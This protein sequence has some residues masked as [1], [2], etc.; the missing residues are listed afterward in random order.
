MSSVDASLWSFVSQI[1]PTQ[2]QKEAASRSHNFLRSILRQGP[3]ANRISQDYLSGSYARDTAVRPI[4]DVDVV[5][6]LVPERWQSP[7]NI[8][9]L[10]S[11]H[12]ILE[13]F[14]AAIRPKYPVSAVFGQRRSVR[15]EL[16]HLDID[17]VPA[18]PVTGYPDFVWIPDR[19]A[20]S[21][22]KSSPKRH[23]EVA[24]R[25][26]AKQ[27]ARLKPLIKLM[28]YWNRGLPDAARFKSFAV[29]TLLIRLFDAV[30]LP[31]L[32]E[33]LLIAFDFLAGLR[34][35]AKL[36]VWTATLGV[37][38]SPFGEVVIPDCA[39]TGTNVAAGTDYQT[40]RLFLDA[41]VLSRDLLL[42]ARSEVSMDRRWAVVRRALNS[43]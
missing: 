34:G 4:D 40:Q 16:Y 27:G 41:A 35:Q 19:A 6:V 28:K 36:S 39:G 22:I 3:L 21:W 13:E 24:T 11:P 17:V 1:E 33:G 9:S 14:A 10:Q 26:N 42:G 30:A 37:S 25:V 23:S 43:L 20:T 5:F 12:S 7:Y 32:E 29:E 31:S 8:G 15:L 18:A 2:A 38:F